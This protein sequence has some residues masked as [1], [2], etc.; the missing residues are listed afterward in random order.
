MLL[1]GV[2]EECDSP[3]TSNVVLVPK[4]GGGTRVCIDYRQV[5]KVTVPDPYPLP[6]IDDLLHSSR[7]FD[8]SRLL[9]SAERN[10]STS[11]LEALGVVWAV[12]KFRGYIE[13]TH[14]IVYSDHQALRSLMSLKTPTDRLE[15]WALRLQSFDLEIHYTPERCNAVANLLSR[16]PEKGDAQLGDAPAENAQ[17]LDVCSVSIDLP[18]R[19]HTARGYILSGGVLYRYSP[20]LNSEEP[21]LVVP[22]Q[23]R[24]TLLKEYHDAATAGNYGVERTLN[25][26][27]Q[28]YYWLGMSHHIAD[29][30]RKC[31]D[32]Q[33]Y[34]ANNLK[35]AG[36]LQTPVMR[37]RFEVLS[38]DLFGPLVES[39][40]GLRWIFIVEDTASR[41]IKLFALQEDE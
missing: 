16:I 5:N 20:D 40:T 19:S 25:R 4:K 13:G 2:I 10:Y 23:E 37:Q 18:R 41:W 32:C 31:A 30:V 33:R 38:I 1:L 24:E 3:W 7:S 28:C 36:L 8:C 17:K 15:R 12:E 9:S 26:I 6:R 22:E 11:E 29:Y 35:P 34:K 14:V 39:P 27:A 21:Q